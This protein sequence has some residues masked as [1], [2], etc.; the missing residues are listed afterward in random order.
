MAYCIV[1]VFTDPNDSSW[2]DSFFSQVHDFMDR[3][4]MAIFP[5]IVVWLLAGIIS[6]FVA[7]G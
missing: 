3:D 4:F 1:V 2:R 5:M 6:E 7:Y